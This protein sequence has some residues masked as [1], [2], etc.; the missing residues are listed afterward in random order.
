LI[1][2]LK[3]S[4]IALSSLGAHKLRTLLALIG[5]IIGVGSVIAMIS[6]GEGTKKEVLS[7]IED[8]GTNLLIVSAGQIQTFGG[9]PSL[10]GNVTTLTWKDADAIENEIASVNQLS[11]AQ[12]KNCKIKWRDQVV[13]TSVIG[14]TPD[15]PEVRNFYPVQG[16]FFSDAEL[17]AA[18]RV[19]VLGKTIKEN[20]FGRDNPIGELIRIENAPFNVIGVMEEKGLNVYGQD[21]DDVIFIPLTTGLRRLFNLTHINNIYIQVRD[22]TSMEKA[23]REVEELLRERHRLRP[24]VGSDFTIQSQSELMETQTEVTDTFTKLLGSVAVVS[25]LVGGI[26]ILAVMLITVK[27]RTR[28]IGIRRAV[29]A[30]KRDILIQFLFEA[31]V[32]SIGGGLIG[33]M[34]GVLAA[35]ITGSITKWPIF[36]PIYSILLSF[37]FAIIIG[38]F[39]GVFPARRAAQL[40]PVEALRYE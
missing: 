36:T 31:S 15:F 4:K 11:P 33:I 32:L 8:M 27:E 28:E 30:K 38:I 2:L 21:E 17:G 19:A 1:N 5:I 25:L 22:K 23:A 7:K 40:K 24:G 9:R 12:Q 16:E 39:F 26:G 20:L 6:I 14:V 13:T 10:V 34:L 37:S 3:G 35:V 18:M 29:G